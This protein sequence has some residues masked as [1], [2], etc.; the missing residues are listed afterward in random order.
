M[1]HKTRKLVGVIL[2]LSLLVAAL[3]AF[4]VTASAADTT[5]TFELGANG[6]ASHYDN[7][8]SKTSYSETVGDYTLSIT[9]GTNMYP[10]SRDAKGNGCIKL[11][12]SSKTGGFSF[13]VPDDVTSVVIAV[14]KYKTDATKVSVN[15]TAYTISTSSNDGAY[16]D[17]V[18]D[19]T[20]N[21]TVT[22]TGTN[23]RT[24][25]NSITY[26]IPGDSS[27]PE[28]E[29]NYESVVTKPTCSAVGFTTYT[30]S[31]CGDSYTDDETDA[32][33]H[34]PGTEA[35]CE[36]PQTCTACGTIVVPA[37]GHNYVDGNCENCGKEQPLEATIAFDDASKRTTSTTN[38]QVW[39]ESGITVT[40]DKN[41]YNQN[42]AEYSNPVRFYA[43]TKV[44]VAYPGMTQI[45]VNANTAAYATALASS[46]G[47]A[48][49][50][51]D[52]VVTITLSEV[53]DSFSVTLNA[54]V[55]VDSI[56]VTATKQSTPTCEHE[57]TYACDKICN[58]CNELTREDANHT[59][60]HV[61]AV[62]AKCT[63]NGNIEYWYCEI[64]GY[65]WADEALTQQ[66]NLMNVV[67]PF[68]GHSYDTAEVVVTEDVPFVSYKCACGD[69]KIK[70][71]ATFKGASIRYKDGA[72]VSE[73]AV[74]FGYQF[75]PNV[76]DYIVSWSW[77]YEAIDGNAIVSGTQVGTAITEAGVSNLVFTNIPTKR[78]DGT[79]K[80]TLTLVLEIK[81]VQ[82]TY[83]EAEANERV[84][85]VVLGAIVD[86]TTETQ[87]ARDYAQ[88][89]LDAF[90]E[91]PDDDEPAVLPSNDEDGN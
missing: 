20:T 63:E 64:C 44:T 47:N 56:T 19:T 26:V 35:D 12:S 3:A 16:T 81:D 53:S 11:G 73:L 28:C 58:K 10:G 69:E 5:V 51:N 27:E 87:E 30:C 45:V 82:Y 80:V 79:F 78:I 84:I 75:D 22:F 54:Q 6:S 49:T 66:T 14:G 59:I 38:Q 33:A 41:T 42:L 52:K 29:H 46:V 68:T 55:R 71:V 62:D 89:V 17:I 90:A 23:K 4:S 91:L 32:L 86:D 8:S 7:N 43:G 13:T 72:D 76:L 18:V 65:A 50:A 36:N 37:I 83:T 67:V 39:Q 88:D 25:V 40:Y 77:D 34:T 24:M 74:R 70:N 48:A 31:K 1:A 15:D 60:A 9:G 21:K 85:S 2:M 57:Y 61:E